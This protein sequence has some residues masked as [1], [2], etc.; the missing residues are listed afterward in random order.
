MVQGEVRRRAG[1]KRKARESLEAA[2]QMF[3][4]LGARLWSASARE[5]L[6]RIG[7]RAP[8]RWA[9]TRSEERVAKL[10]AEGHTNKEVASALF[11]SV[12]TVQSTL[13][14]VFRKL[15]VRSRGELAHRLSAPVKH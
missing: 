14:S 3:E 2:L 4:G 15:D 7:G 11:I 10:V 13:R 9:L 8:S 6:A 1:Q 5:E 12:N